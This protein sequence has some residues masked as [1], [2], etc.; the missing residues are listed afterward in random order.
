MK[1]YIP[2]SLFDKAIFQKGGAN[3]GILFVIAIMA[4][5]TS[6]AY[7]LMGGVA[8]DYPEA[9]KNAPK[10][11]GKQEII[12][13][14]NTDPGKKNLQLQTFKVKTTCEDKIAV[15]F[16]IDVS[17]SMGNGNKQVNEKN[18]INS[19]VSRMT[20]N[21]VIGIQVFSDPNNV[22]EIVP[23]SLYKDVKTQVR[24]TIN[25]LS[26]SGAT[27]TRSALDLAKQKLSQ[28]ISE[29]RFP[30]YK[31]N[32]IFLSDGVPEA[33][34]LIP[35]SQNCLVTS[36]YTDPL[37]NQTTI[38]CFAR[39]QDPRTPTN[40]PDEIKTLGV[41]IYSIA[42]TDPQDQPMKS[43]L[44]RLLSDVSS[45]PNS[46]YFYESVDG[47]D[48]TAILDNVLKSICEGGGA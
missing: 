20:D 10:N 33:A 2:R 22:R 37:T 47:T 15:D 6:F 27:S 28:A 25:S 16:L 34:G 38:R 11:I 26:A 8:P 19:F 30:D 4:T 17:G 14:Q 18:A 44:L 12:F 3:N 1:K 32:L 39:I 9:T 35:N 23:I 48:L 21:S 40:I 43:E 45:D 41:D 36:P 13:E 31:Y 29:N 24:N 5:I 42:I 46:T 7:L